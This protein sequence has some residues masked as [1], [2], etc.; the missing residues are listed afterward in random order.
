MSKEV[1]S[2]F[3]LKCFLLFFFYF[4]KDVLENWSDFFLKCLVEFTSEPILAW[5]FLFQK[6]INY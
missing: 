6:V 3:L 2:L 1:F 5:C 4:L